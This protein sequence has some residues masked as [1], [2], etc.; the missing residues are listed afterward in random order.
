MNL[1]LD[2]AFSTHR[3][4]LLI[5]YGPVQYKRHKPR[6]ENSNST[7]YSYDIVKQVVIQKLYRFAAFKFEKGAYISSF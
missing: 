7:Y 4:S 2:G 5:K 6:L 3:F 1:P